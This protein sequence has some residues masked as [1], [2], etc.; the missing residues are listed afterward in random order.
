MR[1][2]KE[3]ADYR[4]R[5]YVVAALFL[6]SALVVSIVYGQQKKHHIRML[7]TKEEALENAK[8]TIRRY[9][10]RLSESAYLVDGLKKKLASL[11]SEIKTLEEGMGKKVEEKELIIRHQKESMMTLNKTIAENEAILMEKQKQIKELVRLSLM[12]KAS[13]DSGDVVQKFHD[14]S[15]GKGK[16]EEDDWRSLYSAVESM[17]PGFKETVMSVPRNP[18]LSIKTAYLIKIGLNNS[19]IAN[20]TNSSRQTVWDRVK[21]V[22]GYL[23][24]S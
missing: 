18:D 1:A 15:F 8:D 11:E 24:K 6:L 21:K 3:T 16:I 14:A 5:L 10:E 12:E 9:D 23:E 4:M 20:L 17:Y 22:R 2:R 19:Q 7:L 13:I